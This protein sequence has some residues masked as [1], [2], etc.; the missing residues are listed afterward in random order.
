[1]I[2]CNFVEV[3]FFTV[4]DPYWTPAFCGCINTFFP[5]L[6][7]TATK[8]QIKNCYV[9]ALLGGVTARAQAGEF[10]YK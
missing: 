1:M 9:A 8:E 6:V 10:G 3:N 5:N 2:A 4:L 7:G